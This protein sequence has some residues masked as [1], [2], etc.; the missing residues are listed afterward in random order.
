MFRPFHL[1]TSPGSWVPEVTYP[2]EALNQTA[3]WDVV[4]KLRIN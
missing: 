4:P 2:A 3:Y 1:S